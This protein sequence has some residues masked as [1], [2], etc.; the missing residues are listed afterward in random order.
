MADPKC[1]R[2]ST[3]TRQRSPS[4]A[5]RRQAKPEFV[6]PQLNPVEV[7]AVSPVQ[8]VRDVPG[9]YPPSPPLRPKNSA[10]NRKRS[11]PAVR[12]SHLKASTTLFEV[13]AHTPKP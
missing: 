9:P 6:M 2:R 8:T 11:N 1:T 7:S 13:C 12:R 4:A 5:N 10:M 3:P